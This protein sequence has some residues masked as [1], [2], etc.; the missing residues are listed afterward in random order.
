MEKPEQETD[1]WRILL[2]GRRGAELLLV[3]SRSGIRLPEFRIPRWQRIVPHLNEQAKQL[4]NLD[5]VCLF[6]FDV[7]HSEPTAVHC[8]YHAMEVCNPE[9]LARVAPNFVSLSGLKEASFADKR[10]YLAVQQAM[11]FD[12]ATLP[13]ECQGPFSDFGAFGRISAWVKE[14]L[15]H[16]GFSW[17]GTFRQLQ[18]GA[19]FALV[20]F[21]TARGAV[22]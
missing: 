8:R 7:P 4:W 18:A 13:K 9:E 1:A 16:S 14:Q 19:S 21:Q 6:P 3:A 22:W 12:G 5:T 17:N 2:F 15:G 11:G 10:D 20:Q